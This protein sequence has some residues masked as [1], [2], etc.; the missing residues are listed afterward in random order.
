MD[1]KTY[2]KVVILE[3]APKRDWA[4]KVV[5]DGD[6]RTEAMLCVAH[7]VMDIPKHV[8]IL[9]Y[10]GELLYNKIACGP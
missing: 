2:W 4:S 6:K 10:S 5:Y 3:P 7:I 8:I 1:T 9:I